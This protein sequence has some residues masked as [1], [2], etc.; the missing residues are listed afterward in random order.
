M[1]KPGDRLPRFSA[2]DAVSPLVFILVKFGT[3]TAASADRASAGYSFIQ[4][5]DRS[6]LMD[7]HCRDRM[8]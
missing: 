1:E 2:E 8:R 7:L 3:C 5:E 6:Y 4:I